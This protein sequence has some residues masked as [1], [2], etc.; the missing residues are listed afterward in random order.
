MSRKN[1]GRLPREMR[2][3]R[4]R[5]EGVEGS[6]SNCHRELDTQFRRMAQMQMELDEIRHAVNKLTPRPRVRHK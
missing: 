2:L 1:Q 4:E 3:L 6:V 5:L